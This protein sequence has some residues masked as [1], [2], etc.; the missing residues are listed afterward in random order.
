MGC[1]V[2]AIAA[3]F[4]GA[5]PGEDG[6]QLPLRLEKGQ[7]FVYRGIYSE[8]VSRPG[9][10]S[11]RNCDLECLIFILNTAPNA[12]DAAFLTIQRTPKQT[13]KDLPPIARMELAKVDELGRIKFTRK[14]SQPRLPP[15]QPPSL[16]TRAFVELPASG[17]SGGLSWEAAEDGERP[18]TWTVAGVDHRSCGDCLRLIGRQQSDSWKR[19]GTVGWQREDIVWLKL[20]G[21]YAVRI[22]RRWNN[23]DED[24]EIG[25]RSVMVMELETYNPATLPPSEDLARRTEIQHTQRFADE[26]DALMQSPGNRHGYDPLLAQIQTHLKNRAPTTYREA[27][28]TLRRNVEA[29]RNG[30]RAPDLAVMGNREPSPADAGELAPE[31]LLADTITGETVRLSRLSG[32]PVVLIFFKPNSPM[33]RHVLAYADDAK[34]A[35]AG[36]GHVVALAVSGEAGAIVQLRSQ[37]RVKIPIHDGRNAVR[38]FAGESTPRIVIL[39]K[40]GTIHS[41]TPGWGGEYPERFAKELAGLL[42]P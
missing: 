27:L 16:E 33:V 9:A 41:I 17:V 26:F 3:V 12:T 22:E 40:S 19:P 23:R 6:S 31:M 30:E 13:G 37:L 21:G 1:L 42:Q 15:E 8:T 24:G 4:A 18:M 10:K 11:T 38:L 36:K 25:H 2:V 28:L 29:A 14:S 20:K 35:Y 34:S 5:P 32:Q 7:E 39:D